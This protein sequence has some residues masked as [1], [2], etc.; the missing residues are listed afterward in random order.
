MS[1][2]W[3]GQVQDICKVV[4]DSPV[5]LCRAVLGGT[6]TFDPHNISRLGIG[7]QVHARKGT[8]E[9]TLEARCVGVAAAD[10]A[11]WFPTTRGVQVANFPDFYV[12]ADDGTNSYEVLLSDCQPASITIEQGNGEDAEVE[13]NLALKAATVDPAAGSETPAYNS[14]KG[15]TLN[16]TVV[17]VGADELG[18]MSW[19]LANDLGLKIWNPRN[20]KATKTLPFGWIITQQAPR[21][22]A[23]CSD[24]GRASDI[25]S[26]DWT[27]EDI[28]I[29]LA[30]GTAA[31][32]IDITCRDFIPGP[33]SADFP[34]ED[35][36]GHAHEWIPGSGNVHGRV[37]FAAGAG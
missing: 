32:D 18:I 34:P 17:T 8:T 27:P 11:L 7:S 13:V 16:D 33:W 22:Q 9:A 21:F 12:Q 25:L 6:L 3:T 37:T 19:S 31:E 29:A 10:L 26:D 20:T 15:H 14:L 2:V 24:F 1:N 28:V 35:I 4:S 5:A 30:N 36:V 23:V